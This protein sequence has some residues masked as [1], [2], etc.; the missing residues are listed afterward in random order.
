M[1]AS[2]S[3]RVTPSSCPTASSMAASIPWCARAPSCAPSSPATMSRYWDSAKLSQNVSAVR[4][5][6]RTL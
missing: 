1:N 2:I 3:R 5:G 6:S 4:S